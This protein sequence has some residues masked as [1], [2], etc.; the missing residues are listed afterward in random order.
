M[1][2]IGNPVESAPD[3]DVGTRGASKRASDTILDE[4]RR[5]IVMLELPPGTVYTE[6]D[7]SE[8]LDCSRTPLREVLAQLERERLVNRIPHRGLSIAELS[9]V[10]LGPLLEA[11]DRISGI[12]AEL[13][14][15]RMTRDRMAALEHIIVQANEANGR[16]DLPAIADLHFRFHHVL[17][18][19]TGNSYLVEVQDT[20]QRLIDRFVLLALWRAGVTVGALS[21]HS[22][23]LDAVKTSDPQRAME[24]VRGHWDSCRERARQAF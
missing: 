9:M 3:V 13:A 2:R 14:T 10:D 16:G 21:D 7:L 17:A 12:I 22:P 23:I 6:S 1:S 19:A 5:K 4:L 24:A 20:L 15:A 18:E 8:L 11:A